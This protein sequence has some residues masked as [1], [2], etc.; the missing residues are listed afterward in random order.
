MGFR[1]HQNLPS[2]NL[3]EYAPSFGAPQP[4][5]LGAAFRQENDVLNLMDYLSRP[6]FAPDPNFSYSDYAKN[7]P[8]FLRN[9][10][11]FVGIESGPEWQFTEQ[12]LN[13]EMK[14]R[15]RIAAGGATGIAAAM[16]AGLLS[17]TILIPAGGGIKAGGSVLKTALTTSA[18]VSLGASVQEGMLQLNQDERTTAET[19]TGIGSAAV[20]GAVLGGAAQ[21]LL[22]GEADRIVKDMVDDARSPAIQNLTHPSPVGLSAQATPADEIGIIPASSQFADPGRIATSFGIADLAKKLRLPKKVVK[23]LSMDWFGPITRGFGS[24]SEVVRGVTNQISNAALYTDAAL[25]GSAIAKGGTIQELVK[26][27]YYWGAELNRQT[28]TAYIEWFKA[29]GRGGSVKAAFSLG[30]YKEFLTKIGDTMFDNIQ[31]ISHADTEEPIKAMAEA[32]LD[33]IF[34]AEIDNAQ[35]VGMQSWVQLKDKTYALQIA[36]QRVRRDLAAQEYDV[37][38]TILTENASRV[39]RSRIAEPELAGDIVGIIGKGTK[40]EKL[41]EDEVEDLADSIASAIF[42]MLLGEYGRHSGVDVLHRFGEKAARFIYIDPTITWSNG[43]TWKEFLER[44]IEKL[45]R[46]FTR[47][48][49]GDIELVRKFGVIEADDFESP[50]AAKFWKDF[51]DEQAKRREDAAKI[52]DIAE[53][54]KEMK[55]IADTAE[56]FQKDMKVLVGRI[57]HRYGMP[58]DPTSWGHRAGRMALQLNTMRLMG[59]VVISSFADLA[60]TVMRTGVLN[61]YRHGLKPL[62]T[63]F[64]TFRMTVRELQFAG[65]ALDVFMHGRSGMM[66]DLFDELEYGNMLERAMQFGTSKIGIVAA[67]DYW[68][69]GMKQFAGAVW[70]GTLAD[71]IDARVLGKATSWQTAMLASMN[72]DEPVARKILAKMKDGKGGSEISPGMFL[73]NTESWSE[74]T[75]EAI[76]AGLKEK[77]KG[78]EYDKLVK[79]TTRFKKEQTRVFAELHREGKTLQ[80]TFRAALAQAVDSTIVTP[81]LERPAWV[82]AST[83]GRLIAQF[84]SYTLS[85]TLQVARLAAQDVRVG[86]VA[87]V[88]IGISFSLALGMISY[89]TWAQ[90][91]GGRTRKRM[92][93][94][95]EAALNGDAEALG[96]WADEAVNRSG[97]IGM[98]AEVQKFGERIPALAPYVNFAGKPPAR[99]PYVNPVLDMFGPT[100]NIIDNLGNIAVTFDDP[101]SSTFRSFKQLM[102]YQ[103]LMFVRQLFD[104][105]NDAAMRRVGIDP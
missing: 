29:Q 32:Y 11:A 82:D 55:D 48:M 46:S 95:L 21:Y 28:K 77:F 90:S 89:Y 56:Q 80:R 83:A 72:I 16:F 61:T 35:E 20:L 15:Q 38:K 76:D 42:P 104:M 93:N 100:A 64:K 70:M 79:D 67:F 92:E 96:R 65:T 66:F 63:D 59:G 47:S 73:P 39:L 3:S 13:E 69:A 53:R 99:S 97:L 1:T 57:R 78:A 2:I 58:A 19:M 43:R 44:D 101:T 34:R 40:A 52:T 7:S 88:A 98:L 18:W 62:L 33:K 86:N 30:S 49:A 31:G 5:L 87:P 36:T 94:E 9:P 74:V 25:S 37:V 6:T 102:P 24:S 22:P 68:N 71:A 91:V 10:E 45:S 14:D 85:S 54:K 41:T 26:Q 27:H 105:L 51:A 8:N 103:N 75:D 17:P 60:R 81:G 84:R 23:A 4:G 12:R 50:K